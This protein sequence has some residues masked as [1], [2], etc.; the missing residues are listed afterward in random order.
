MK[1]IDIRKIYICEL[2]Q[3]KD[4]DLIGFK[5]EVVTYTGGKILMPVY[6]KIPQ[7]IFRFE[8]GK[9]LGLFMQTI[10]GYKHILTEVKYNLPEPSKEYIGKQVINPYKIVKFT[11]QKPELASILF[12]E[13]QS[14]KIGVDTINEIENKINHKTSD[15]KRNKEEIEEKDLLEC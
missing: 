3:L 6:D 4:I 9:R 10:S 2:R 13:Y 5:E 1:K 15:N 14:Y 12:N 7:Y 8:K 11:E